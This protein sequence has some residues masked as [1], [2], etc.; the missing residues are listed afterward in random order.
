[1]QHGHS[2]YFNPY[3]QP[4]S[5]YSAMSP[6]SSGLSPPLSAFPAA[7]Q[8]SHAMPSGGIT[9]GSPVH[10]GTS[11]LAACAA[12]GQQDGQHT[13]TAFA[14]F[15]A[16]AAAAAVPDQSFG[17]QQC[18][19]DTSADAATSDSRP[20]GLLRHGSF[21]VAS[22]HN[23]PMSASAVTGALALANASTHGGSLFGGGGLQ[24][25]DPSGSGGS[26][27]MASR[28][29]A[30]MHGPGVHTFPPSPI[31][32]LVIDSSILSDG[33]ATTS[34]VSDTKCVGHTVNHGCKHT[35]QVDGSIR[36]MAF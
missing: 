36:Q 14:P 9:L 24:G 20:Q 33:E 15:A 4:G 16:A 29:G 2:A 12:S 13:A 19:M 10:G 3:R 6:P 26:M 25:S 32:R 1:M 21:G 35:R 11:A 27:S 8:P 23:L 34:T 7:H 22:L 5:S 18:A 28:A 30:S 31:R 17:H